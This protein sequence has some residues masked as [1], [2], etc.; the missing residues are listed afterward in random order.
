MRSWKLV[1]S[2]EVA[3]KLPGG[4]ILCDVGIY[5]VLEAGMVVSHYVVSGL[6]LLGVVVGMIGALYMSQG[7]LGK[8]ANVV[9][10]RLTVSLPYGT[11]VLLAMVSN[12]HAM[13]SPIDVIKLVII[14]GYGV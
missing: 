8:I 2:Q 9:L 3:E 6:T 1:R 10:R 4:Y 14:P 11:F 7:L 12:A 13:R 5:A